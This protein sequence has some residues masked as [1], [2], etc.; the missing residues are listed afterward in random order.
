[1]KRARIAPFAA[2]ALLALAPSARRPRRA[3]SR[4]RTAS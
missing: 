2:I 4:P 3:A 1:M